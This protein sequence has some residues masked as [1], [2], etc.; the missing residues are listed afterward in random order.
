MPA[1][2]DSMFSVRAMPWHRDVVILD[3][4]PGSWAEARVAA[5]L[6]WD[7]MPS[8][9]YTLRGIDDDG[10]PIYEE[11]PGWKNVVRSDTGATLALT[12]DS[13]HIIDH[14]AM[15]QV[16]EAILEQDGLKYETAGALHGGVAVWVLVRLDDPI[17]LP[18]DNSLTLPY[19]ALTT[20]HDGMGALTARATAVR[21]VCA[22]TWRAAEMEGSRH[23]ATYAFHHTA[24][25]RDRVKEARDAITGARREI[26]EYVELAT[27]LLG[28]KV[29]KRQRELF[30][31]EFIPAPPDGVVSDRVAK[32]LDDARASLR[33]IMDSPTTAPVANTAYGLVQ[34]AGEYCDHLRGYRSNDSYLGRTLLKPEPLKTRALKMVRELVATEK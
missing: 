12:K 14:N 29:T 8:Q 3:E 34:A 24:N 20:R 11:I 18:G 33:A 7:P 13:Y 22:N 19:V 26:R 2:V 25:W 15:G 1:N 10:Q 17:Q 21:I 9:V 30:L 23:G 28:I 5:G 4:Y 6:G 27:E 32:N 31:R 16:I